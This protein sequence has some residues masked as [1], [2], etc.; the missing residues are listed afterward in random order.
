MVVFNPPPW[1]ISFRMYVGWR[2]VGGAYHENQETIAILFV[3]CDPI[4]PSEISLHLQSRYCTNLQLPTSVQK[5]AS[6]IAK[7][8]VDMDLA[9]G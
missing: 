8:A 3:S 9:P 1:S 4:S 7:K 6:H 5:A 2:Q